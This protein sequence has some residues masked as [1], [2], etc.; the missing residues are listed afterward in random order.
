MGR[1]DEVWSQL[2]AIGRL[3][4]GAVAVRSSVRPKDACE[5]T[6]WVANWR[7]NAERL[8]ER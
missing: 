4:R 5:V 6:W 8:S 2:L 7:Y 3:M 1:V